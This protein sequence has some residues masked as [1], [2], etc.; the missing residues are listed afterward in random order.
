[1]KVNNAHVLTGVVNIPGIKEQKVIV[2]F[3]KNIDAKAASMKMEIDKTQ[4]FKKGLLQQ[5]FV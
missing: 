1:M 5:M 2:D 4:Q 3:L